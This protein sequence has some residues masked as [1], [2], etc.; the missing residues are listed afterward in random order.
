M[1]LKQIKLAGFKSFVDPTTVSFPGNRCAIVGPNGCGKSNII[2]AVRWVMGE[3]SARQLRGEAL[4]DVIFNGS[5]TRKPTAL[6]SIELTFDN[7]DGRI[8]GEYAQYSEIAIRRQVTRDSQSGYFLNGTKCRRRDIMDIFL[9]TGFGPR[10]YSIIEQGMISQLID[11]KPE[12]LRI[13]LEEA[14]GISKYKERRRETETR[15]RHTEE[16]LDRLNDVREELG[17]QLD[18]L[19]R[20]ARAAER[21]RELKETERTVTA[22]LHALRLVSLEAALQAREAEIRSLEVALERAIAGQRELDNEIEKGRSQHAQH[23]DEFNRVQGRYYQLGADI[24]RIEEAI[25]YNQQRVQQLE[26]DLDS[27]SQRR[28]ETERQLAMDEEQIQSLRSALAEAG[29]K[30]E[31]ARAEDVTSSATLEAAEASLNA[32]RAS[33]EAFNE[34]AAANQRESDVEASRIEHLEQVLQRLRARAAQLEDEAR[35][36]VTGDASDDI[37][38]LAAGIEAEMAALNAAELDMEHC[39]AELGAS[40]EDLVIRE[41]VLEEARSDVQQLRHELASLEAVQQAAL[42][43]TDGAADDWLRSQSLTEAP[44]AGEGLAVVASW[45]RAVEA[46]LGDRLQAVHVASTADFAEHLTHLEHGVVTLFEGG[47]AAQPNHDLPL[48][49]S[50]VTSARPVGSLLHGVYAASSLAIALE[51]RV[52]LGPA[53]SIITREGIWLGADWLRLDRGADIGHGIIERARSLDVLRERVEQAELNLTELQGRVSDG[54]ARVEG[55]DQR[56]HELHGTINGLSQTLGQLRTDHGVHR[57]RLEE[58]DARRERLN[59]E[60]TETEQQALHEAGRLLAARNKLAQAERAREAFEGDREALTNARE[61]HM[62]AV[63]EARQRARADRDRFHALNAERQ[64]LASRLEAT[65][66][67]RQRLLRQQQELSE[68]HGELTAGVESSQAPLPNLRG[69]LDGKLAERL[70]VEHALTDVRRSLEAA[71]LQVRELEAKRGEHAEAVDGVRSALESA[72]VDRQGLH[73][74]RTSLVEQLEATGLELESVRAA[75]A[76]EATEAAWAEQLEKIANRIQRLGPINLAAIEEY[77]SSA[78][79]KLYL[80]QQH[81]DLTEALETLGNAI[82]RIDRETRS[83]FKET[84]DAV[85]QGLG[86]RFAKV[87]GGGHAYLE[88]TGE[89]LL[90]TG[91]TLMARPPGKRNASINLLSG[92]EKALTAIALIFSIFQLNPSPVCLLDEVDAPLDDSNVVRFAN[93]IREMSEG[94]QFIVITHNKLTMEMAE[95]LM[96]VTMNEPGVSR[97]VSVDVEEAAQMAAV[98]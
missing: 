42:G 22:E 97:L 2:D 69:E 98:V 11:A 29:P 25:S 48:L 23:S 14:A 72:R 31:A 66:T 40:R 27:V 20:Q 83:R 10:S 71:E 88:L 96:G 79:R 91:V 46:V 52:R 50:F 8:G 62:H 60:A 49:A 78:E 70:A 41:Q 5:T 34:R 65:E 19:Q 28:K 54:R 7:S 38:E 95:H 33:W 45:E 76:A 67:A 47:D 1:R 80:D 85:N 89:D 87:F 58:A 36:I 16:N 21:Y 86:E 12:D 13:Y 17:R 4:T 73:V 37:G 63:E 61:T 74:K 9:G 68:R 84:F 44:R 51:H 77:E 32:W 35:N 59:G 30:V 26:L 81:G 92:G 94:V 93:L 64:T 6:A 57:V 15:I 56:R 55:L 90:D 18:H 43:R 39:L 75:L 24:A 3:S 53:E 82:R